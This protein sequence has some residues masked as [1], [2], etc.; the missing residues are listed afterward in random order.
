MPAGFRELDGITAD[1]GIEAWGDS[2]QAAFAS[3]AMGLFHLM[4]DPSVNTRSE[5]RQVEIQADTL[6]ALLVRFLNEIIFLDETDDFIPA[7]VVS[8]DIR[9]DRLRASLEG[10][11]M[12]AASQARTGHIKAATYHELEIRDSGDGFRIRVIFDV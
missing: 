10:Q 1:V 2:L 3:A 11:T 5:T 9:G 4:A 7:G 8:L 12:N 6:P